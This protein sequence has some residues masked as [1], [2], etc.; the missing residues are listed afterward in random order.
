VSRAT[1]ISRVVFGLLVL[2]TF[3]AFF[4]AQRL[5]RVDPL[6]YSVSIKKYVSP[7]GDGLRDR[8]RL[9]FRTK[10]ADVVTVDVI[11]RSGNVVRTLADHK[12]LKAGVHNFQWNGKYAPQPRGQA[13]PVSDGG[14]R[15][16]ITMQR[17]GRTFVPDRF[18]VVDSTAPRM[19]VNV[20]GA[21]TVSAMVGRP[22]TV[23]FKFTGITA[24]RRVQFFV[25]RVVGQRT[26]PHPVAAF[27]NAAGK[28]TGDWN[29]MVGQY[30]TRRVRPH[31]GRSTRL[32][33]R[34]FGHL[35]THGT[36]RP[37]PSGGYVIVARACDAAG[38]MGTSSDPLPPRRGSTLGAPGLTL[39]GVQIAPP[40]KPAI[41]G[42][43][44]SFA[45]NPPPG[46]YSYSLRQVGGS[47]AASG[48]ARGPQLRLRVARALNGLY[49][50]SIKALRTVNGERGSARTP[51]V[52]SNRRRAALLVVYPAIAW[53]ATNPVDVNGDGYGDGYTTLPPGQELRVRTD[54][55][56]ATPQLP[57]GFSRQEGALADFLNVNPGTPSTAVT[58]DF[59]LAA[60]PQAALK[61]RK[62]ILFAGDER[63][64]TPQ[65]G[66][67]LRKFVE[68]GGKVAFFAPDAFRRTVALT[69]DEMT[70]PSDRRERNIFGEATSTSAIAPAPVVP[71][72]DKL[73]LFRAPTGLFDVFE[74]SF[75]G[76]NQSITAMTA[77]GRDPNHPAVIAYSRG[78]GLV[79][80]VGADGWQ[81]QLVGPRADAN[82]AY[83]TQRIL[84]ELVK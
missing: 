39:R 62:A 38:N 30:T 17:S 69:P 54:R 67:A 81:A 50:L 40:T 14:Y 84:Q 4:A 11:D 1:L 20:V 12:R 52:I 8:A 25:Y 82:V 16:R 31:A 24:A 58:T 28:A 7:N 70:G 5:K 61:R 45:V 43:L 65:L 10:K 60:A 33:M 22:K 9:R 36:P 41:A 68:G 46:G 32:L 78:A 49:E 83:T 3:T 57:A 71:F 44:A 34:C 29:L 72:T 73:S 79:I 6:V 66:I 74:Q 76:P 19:A 48:R 64:I 56:L 15:V 77:A 63:W 59:A 13:A 47:V 2:A 23:P 21:H 35:A 27:A 37:A 75:G 51:V 18:F 80:R 42:T 55:M 53:Q 26:L